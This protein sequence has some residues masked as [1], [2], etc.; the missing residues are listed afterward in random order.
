[1]QSDIKK[2]LY[3]AEA[4]YLQEAQIEKFKAHTTSL[5]Q[6]LTVY[7]FLRDREIEI[8]QPITTELAQ[9]YS[10]EN[11]EVITKALKH[12]IAV[13]RYG[14]MAMLLNSPTYLQNSILDWLAPTIRVHQMQSIANAIYDLL[15]SRL[16]KLLAT[17]QFVLLEPFLKQMQTSLVA[18][19]IASVV[20]G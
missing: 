19:P 13:M 16:Q 10:G 18:K 14:A 8:F 20:G 7:E 3:E 15:F 1:M 4:N 6:R 11:L 2:I 9:T 5:A 12:W 17:P